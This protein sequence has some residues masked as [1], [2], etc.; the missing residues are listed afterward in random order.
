MADNK[1]QTDTMNLNGDV[2]KYKSIFA[3]GKDELKYKA[4]KLRNK[5][6]EVDRKRITLEYEYTEL[7]EEY[8]DIV[9]QLDRLENGK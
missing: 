7:L 8:N 9:K 1:K 5:L 4:K 2:S 6:S 3:M